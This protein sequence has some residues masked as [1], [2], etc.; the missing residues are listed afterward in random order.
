MT[1]RWENLLNSV[2]QRLQDG[3]DPLAAAFLAEKHLTAVEVECLTADLATIVRGYALAPE[4]LKRQVRA[5]ALCTGK[6][7][8]A[9]MVAHLDAA[10][11]EGKL[12]EG[13]RHTHPRPGVN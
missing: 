9:L 11:V 10:Y 6:E 4:F 13:I 5:F 2:A 8:A 3:S 7:Q 1:P 12:E